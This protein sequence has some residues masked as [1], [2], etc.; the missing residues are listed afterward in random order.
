MIYQTP[1]PE[2]NKILASLTQGMTEILRDNLVGIYLMGSLS[3]GDFNSDNSDID[4]VVLV[5]DPLSPE[6]LEALKQLHLQVEASHKK[7]A[8][9]IE[10]SYVP[11][12]M[13]HQIQPPK[14]PRPYFGEG[15]FYPEAPYGN[16]WII[17][18]YL[19][20]K[21]GI[22]L[23]GP[24]FKTFVNPIDIE[25]VREACIRDLFEEWKAKM[26]DREW[27]SNSHYQSYIVL[28]LCRI[29]YTVICHETFGFMGK[30]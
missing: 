4:L 23:V 22:P 1:Y 25:D 2:I 10:C 20:Y 9:R 15:I 11:R 3:Y 5:K 19:L 6:Q 29:L 8:K 27:L 28:N 17:N 18:Q 12:E 21:H 30:A 16:E 14:K 24:D 13:L 7:W 26:N